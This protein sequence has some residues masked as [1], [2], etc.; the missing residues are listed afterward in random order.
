LRTNIAAL[1]RGRVCTYRLSHPAQR[2]QGEPSIASTPSSRSWPWL[3]ARM[4]S[5]PTRTPRPRARTSAA[6]RTS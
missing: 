6:P 5:K 4:W 3:P 1:G 2:H